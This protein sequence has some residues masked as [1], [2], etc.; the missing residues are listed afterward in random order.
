M[1]ALGTRVTTTTQDKLIPKLVDTIL[2]SNVFATRMLQKAQKFSGERMKFPV[3]YAKNTTGTSFAGFDT[4]STSATDNRVNLEFV[5][6][7]YQM[8]VALPLD[9]LSA[10]A[11]EEKVLDLAKIEMASTAHD[12]ADDIGTI[13]Y[14]TGTGNGSKDFLGLEAIVDDGTN[15]STY[16]TLA[17]ATYTTLSSTVTASSGTLSLAKMSTLYNAA[18]SGQQAPTVGLVT[19]TVYSL[20][21]QLLQPTERYNKP[22]TMPGG[23]RGLNSKGG[24]TGGTGYTSL[25]YKNFPIL[26][27]EKCT[28]GVMYFVNEDFLNWYALPMAMTEAAK[29]R[30]QDI[31]GNDYSEVTGLGFSWSGW[32]KP[33]N[34]AAVVGHVYLGGELISENP[35]R[36]A[37]LT[38]ITGV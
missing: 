19:E 6:K 1:A 9:G 34:S 25:F 8:S 33:T 5:P 28:S 22:V 7:F 27:D 13:F 32:I 31:E 20:Y 18:S 4:F 15:A 16:G 23:G 38:G 10:N 2:N 36:H 14:S 17:R 24:M 12:M 26:A 35:K 11:T 3:K 37:K 30:S 21:E 29:F